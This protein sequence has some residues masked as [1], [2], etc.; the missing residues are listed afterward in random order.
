MTRQ[1]LLTAGKFEDNGAISDILK[2]LEWCGFIRSYTMMGY[3][4]KSALIALH[5]LEKMAKSLE[6]HAK[7]CSFA[8]KSRT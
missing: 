1:E 4:T 2:D 3:R 8:T 6:S 7:K 5:S